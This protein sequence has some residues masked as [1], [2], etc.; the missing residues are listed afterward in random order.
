MNPTPP[1]LVTD[2][3]SVLSEL[4]TL[5]DQKIIE[6]GCGS[7][8]LARALVERYPGT[9]V[10]GLE[11]DQCQHAKNLAAP[12]EQLKFLLAGAQAIPFPEASFD[13][14]LML[15]SLHHV[16]IPWMAQAIGEVGRVLRQGGHFYVSEPVYHGPLN[17][18]IRLFNDEG[19]VRRA[20]QAAV[21]EAMGSKYWVQVAQRW[22]DMPVRFRDFEDF[23]QRMMRSTFANHRADDEM[24]SAVRER[25]APHCGADGA[26]FTR[27]M[28]VRLLRRQAHST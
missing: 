12:Q 5:S 11:T 25:F 21:D 8:R 10:T 13:L 27:P 18:I 14:V 16:P 6:L 9:H 23:E 4:V 1:D 7:A 19:E 24:L 17:E 28:H 15:K 22:F 3:L 2:E 20:A 26:Y